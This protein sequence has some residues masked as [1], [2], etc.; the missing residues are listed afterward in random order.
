MTKC[1]QEIDR[2]LKDALPHA[3]LYTPLVY[4]DDLAVHATVDAPNAVSTLGRIAQVVHDVMIR[5]G[6]RPNLGPGKTEGMISYHGAGSRDLRRQLEAHEHP[7]LVFET[8]HAGNKELRLVRSYRYLGGIIEDNGTVTPEIRLRT[9]QAQSQIRPLRKTIIS[10][11]QVDLKARRTILQALGTSKATFGIGTWPRLT[12]QQETMWQNGIVGLYRMLQ[13][14][15]KERTPVPETLIHAEL[16]TP[17]QLL[18]QHRTTMLQQ[19]GRHGSAD[20]KKL[21][22]QEA[23]LDNKH[24]FLEMIRGDWK[25]Y[26]TFISAPWMTPLPDHLSYEEMLD[27]VTTQEGLRI[28]K[29]L[30]KH[31][32][33]CHNMQLRAFWAGHQLYTGLEKQLTPG[34]T[35]AKEPGTFRC[36][37]CSGT[38]Q[39]NT[40]LSVHQRQRHK[41]VAVAR[42]FARG[43]EC[44]WCHKNFHTRARCIIHLQ[45]S[46][47]SCLVNLQAA[48]TPLTE[49]ERLS[50]DE[51]DRIEKKETLASGRRTLNMR[52]VFLLPPAAVSQPEEE[53]LSAPAAEDDNSLQEL[54]SSQVQRQARSNAVLEMIVEKLWDDTLEALMEST[55]VGYAALDA[56]FHSLNMDLLT[57]AQYHNLESELFFGIQELHMITDNEQLV[58]NLE[59]FTDFWFPPRKKI[60][61]GSA[62]VVSK[63]IHP[64]RF[65]PTERYKLPQQDTVQEDW[66]EQAERLE[67]QQPHHLWRGHE[68]VPKPLCLGVVYCLLPF[69]GTRRYAD[70][71]MWLQWENLPGEQEIKAIVMD[72]GVD[73]A[74]DMLCLQKLNQWKALIAQGKVCYLHSAPPCETWSAARHLPPPGHGHKPRPLR[75]SANPWMHQHR[76]VRELHQTT[77]GTRLMAAA[78]ELTVWAYNYGVAT[79]LEHPSTWEGR[80]SIWTT[81]AVQWLKALPRFEVF[82]FF[83][84]HFGACALKPTTFLLGNNQTLRKILVGH[85]KTHVSAPVTVL[86][87]LD[88]NEQGQWA[89]AKAKTYPPALCRALARAARQCLRDWPSCEDRSVEPRVLADIAKLC[90]PHDPYGQEAGHAPDF[91]G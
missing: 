61:V 53:E 42:F 21:I 66:F 51:Q 5:H 10:N 80:S 27:F 82:R 8:L 35:V 83:Q 40:A 68:F 59:A 47:T 65:E 24:S 11:G 76:D 81:L 73:E 30:M 43:P 69:G 60:T 89:T 49:E 3:D 72:L 86:K 20:Y 52:K 84:S 71:P 16:P 44:E 32:F 22:L 46:G 63:R 87:G 14:P 48:T 54:P 19:L 62:P 91:H 64:D 38:F 57:D 31:A 41:A 67:T 90:P 88:Q 39:T 6:M 25:W 75:S 37:Q 33:R 56:F 23:V 77:I 28:T 78:L 9:V 70:V 2:E 1:L 17:Q 18:R 29:S 79:S 74:G 55:E 85:I 45:Y 58:M 36:D 50:M 7:H 4:V 15:D 26:N 34:A 12:K 13:R